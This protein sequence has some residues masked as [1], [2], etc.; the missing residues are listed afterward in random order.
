VQQAQARL[1]E[2]AFELGAEIVLVPD[3]GLAW[4][5]RVWSV[6]KISSKVW[7]SSVSRR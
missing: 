7:R 6:W 2:A 4:P 3:Q 1:G 5:V